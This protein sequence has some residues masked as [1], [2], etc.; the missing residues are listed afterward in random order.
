MTLPNEQG[1]KNTKWIWIGL[2]AA[3]LFCLCAVVV[4]GFVF[5]RMGKSVT[6]SVKTDPDA[7]AQAA[8]EIADYT[9]PRGYREQM[10]MNILIY[11]FVIIGPESSN[12]D[13]NLIMLA[14]FDSNVANPEQM[15]QQIQQSFEQQSGRRGA[16]LKLVEVKKVIIRGQESNV[17]VYEGTDQSGAS[18]RQLITSFPGKNGTAILMVAGDTQSWDQ[19]AL[20]AFIKSIR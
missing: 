6:D 17:A 9:L 8:H 13:G 11:S 1:N 20:D 16:N 19:D 10:S 12:Q 7:A 18:V 4:A 3:T 15:K 5:Y 14:Q 2:G